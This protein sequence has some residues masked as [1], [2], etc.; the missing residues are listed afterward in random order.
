MTNH[1]LAAMVFAVW[2]SSSHAMTINGVLSTWE[3]NE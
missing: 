2:S 1:R 3:I